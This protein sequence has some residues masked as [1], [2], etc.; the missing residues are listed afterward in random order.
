MNENDEFLVAHKTS[1]RI[2]IFGIVL[3]T[4]GAI[5]AFAIHNPL[6][7]IWALGSAGWTA[8]ALING[9]TTFIWF[10]IAQHWK[11]IATTKP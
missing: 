9:K 4:I 3:S 6:A 5:M 2:A 11:Q 8:N 1:Q 7:G 10:E